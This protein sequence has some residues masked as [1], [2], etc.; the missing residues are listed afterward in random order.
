MAGRRIC[1]VTET[2]PPEINGVATTVARLAEGL[3]A[4]DHLVSVVC[5]GR[6][7]PAAPSLEPAVDDGV[8]RV[9]GVPL[10]YYPGLRAGLPAGRTLHEAW[11]R[12]RPDVVYVAT[13]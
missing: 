8:T 7:G 1:L 2:Y 13:E 4:R 9:R 6:R 10:P 3:R 5:P 11:T 12:Q